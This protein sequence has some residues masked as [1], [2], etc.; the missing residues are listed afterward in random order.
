MITRCLALPQELESEGPPRFREHT[1]CLRET[2]DA[3]L[4]WDVW[5][6]NDDVTVR[7]ILP[8]IT[9]VISLRRRH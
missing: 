8:L 2:Y 9:H 1:E 3:T 6:V 4:L 5:G 7:S